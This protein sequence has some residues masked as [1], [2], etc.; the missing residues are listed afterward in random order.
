MFNPQS[1]IAPQNM[2]ERYETYTALR[3]AAPVF[4]VPG[5]DLW[6][7]FRYDD[8]RQVISD[9]E[10]FSSDFKYFGREL[11]AANPDQALALQSI[12]GI[13]PPMHR[14]MRSLIAR[15]FTPRVIE[16]YEAR[17][18]GMVNDL[19]D[20]VIERGQMDVIHDLGE[21][22]PTRVIAD[23]LG[24]DPAFQ[25]EFRRASD[26]L[27][28][29]DL[30]SGP[31]P[32]AAQAEQ[33]LVA[34]LGDL[35]AQRRET[36]GDDLTTALVNAEIDG[37]RLSDRDIIAFC[38]LLLVAGNGTTTHLIGNMMLALLENPSEMARLRAEPGLLASAIEESLR[39]YSPAATVLRSTTREVPMGGQTIPQGARIMPVLTSANR[40]ES[41]FEAADRFDITRQTNPHI[42]FGNGIHFCLGAPLARLEARVAFTALLDRLPD[43]T[44]DAD[45]DALRVNPGLLINALQSLPLR[46]TAGTRQSS[47]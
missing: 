12:I 16:Q 3:H 2:R 26:M 33:T 28:Q 47:R 1:L 27:L 36:P 42:A 4:A 44:L 24:I 40:D 19:I 29:A 5:T 43:L 38:E 7:L 37:E 6:F 41:K 11:L 35:I 9:P 10:T 30:T 45:A 31:N 13:D 46:F 23:M 17:I 15:A 8:V 20:A 18:Q 39:Y 14:R 32:A 22:L 21:P 25:D 34:Y